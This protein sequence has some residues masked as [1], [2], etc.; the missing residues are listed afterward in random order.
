[1]KKIIRLLILFSF[2]FI[3][4]VYGQ[5]INVED[6]RIFDEIEITELHHHGFRRII[7]KNEMQTATVKAD[8]SAVSFYPYDLTA[9][10][11]STFG[12]AVQILGSADTPIVAGMTK[13]DF[14][15]VFVTAA[16][17]NSVYKIRIL[18]GATASAALVA[19]HY[20]D[21]WFFGDDTNPNKS[22][23]TAFDI[24]CERHYSGTLVWAQIACAAGAKTAS[25]LFSL[26]EYQK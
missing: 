25:L 13:F 7:S 16:N 2:C 17:S 6:N 3:H 19:G 23:P 14:N 5:I 12:T 24:E 20:T 22:S 8:T 9:A 15:K 4:V 1:M 26:H 18:Y 21:V 10:A 11:D